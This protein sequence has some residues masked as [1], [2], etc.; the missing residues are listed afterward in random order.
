MSG[1]NRLLSGW[2]SQ[3]GAWRRPVPLLVMLGLPTFLLGLG[4]PA[5]YDPHESLYA[6]IAREM[7]LSGDWLT[8]HLNGTR[9]LDKPPLFYWLIALAYKAFGVSEFS[10]RLPVALAGLGGVLATYG[11]GRYYFAGNTGLLAG[12]V[13]TTSVGYF[14]FSRQLLPDMVFTFFT[15]LSVAGLLRTVADGRQHQWWAAVAS[16]SLALA[17]LTKGVLGLFPL[18]IVAG[19]ALCLGRWHTLR[20]LV[21]LRGVLLFTVLTV[22]WHVWIAWQ[23]T[24]YAWH[25]FA[26]EQFWRFLGQRHPIDYIS[27][28]LPIFLLMLFLWLLPWSP[29]LALAIPQTRPRLAPADRAAQGYL[30]LLLWAGMLLTFF[31]TSRARLP[32]YSLPAMPALALLIGRS[33]DDRF[34]GRTSNH[35]G[36][37][38]ASAVSLLLPML[39]FLLLPPYLT[40]YHQVGLTERAVTL[41]RLVFGLIAAGSGVALWGFARRRWG[42]GLLTLTVGMAAAFLMTHQVLV[43]LEPLRSSKGVAALI[44]AQPVQGEHIVLE[45]ERDEPFEYEKVAGLVFYLGQPVD[46]LRRKNPPTPSL[47]LKPTERFLLSEAAFRQLWASAAKVYLVTDSF[48]DGAGVLDRQASVAVVGRVGDMWVLSN[49]P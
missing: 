26:N 30:L 10:A 39:A 43:E 8:P 7:V 47:P 27:L 32:Q 44:A 17:V 9:Y 16:G 37:L 38:I 35:T 2:P 25:Y 41:I 22:P 23:N 24:G 48:G 11:I 49:R 29:Y 21:T 18:V 1:R 5:L 42:V 4:S 12:L 13:L 15:T 28:P 33:L 40:Q 36:L 19:Y 45:I 31:A 6:E 14:V 3:A 34:S 46:L 20:S